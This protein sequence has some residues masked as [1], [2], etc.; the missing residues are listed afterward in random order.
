MSKHPFD[1]KLLEAVEFH[2]AR[3]PYKVRD[4][5]RDGVLAHVRAGTELPQAIAEEIRGVRAEF[6]SLFQPNRAHRHHETH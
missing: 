6:P 2:R 5:I 3:D 4:L 1:D